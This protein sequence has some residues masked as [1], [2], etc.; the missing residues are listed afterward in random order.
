M[1][2]SELR[3]LSREHVLR[4]LQQ[5]LRALNEHKR[6][7]VVFFP[8]RSSFL[9]VVIVLCMIVLSLTLSL[10]RALCLF[11]VQAIVRWT[12]HSF[13]WLLSPLWHVWS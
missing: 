2:L 7:A 12:F 11:S 13:V 10:M 4:R 5:A 6:H 3:S 1:L 9:F 8:P